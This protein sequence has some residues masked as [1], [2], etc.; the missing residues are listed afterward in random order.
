MVVQPHD[1]DVLIARAAS[2]RIVRNQQAASRVVITPVGRSQL[3]PP[4]RRDQTTS[5]SARKRTS[6]A[7]LSPRPPNCAA[8]TTTTPPSSVA[9]APQASLLPASLLSFC[10]TVEPGYGR[11]AV[12]RCA[13]LRDACDDGVGLAH[14][15]HAAIG[16]AFDTEHFLGQRS[17]D[18][19][20]PDH[21]P[22]P[23]EQPAD[24]PFPG[25]GRVGLRAAAGE[26]RKDLTLR[27]GQAFRRRG[28]RRQIQYKAGHR[29]ANH[30]IRQI[31]IR[32]PAR[33]RSPG[34]R[35]RLLRTHRE[36]GFP[37]S[38][39]KCRHERAVQDGSERSAVNGTANQKVCAA[40][41]RGDSGAARSDHGAAY[42]NAS[43]RLRAGALACAAPPWASPCGIGARLARHPGP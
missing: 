27:A 17:A 3:R 15:D 28:F 35:S 22:A 10:Q 11:L 29:H 32:W 23:V 5:P 20:L 40:A 30:A 41:C 18:R 9:A 6:R 21:L 31:A 39:K 7:L 24:H 36:L 2:R 1:P 26:F 33:N 25:A 4:S 16:G 43:C 42:H 37:A 34:P 13:L 12:A 19:L 38:K 14:D 8:E